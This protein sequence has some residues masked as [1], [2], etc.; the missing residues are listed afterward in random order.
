MKRSRELL[1]FLLGAVLA[2]VLTI[3]IGRGQNPDFA[4]AISPSSAEPALN[5]TLDNVQIDDLTLEQALAVLSDKAHVPI[6]IKNRKTLEL[7]GVDFTL[8]LSLNARHSTLASALRQ[9]LEPRNWQQHT[10]LEFWPEGDGIEVG[11]GADS[12]VLCVYDLARFGIGD[13][14]L[15]AS[16]TQLFSGRSY[17]PSDRYDPLVKVIVED[18][19]PDTWQESGGTLGIID[20]LG[21]RMV[22]GQTWENQQVISRLLDDLAPTAAGHYVQHAIP[23]TSLGNLWVWSA[24]LQRFVSEVETPAEQTLRRELHDVNIA[25]Q[26]FEEGLS[27]VGIL[28]DIQILTNWESFKAKDFDIEKPVELF[29]RRA[30][31]ARALHLALAPFRKG[32]RALAFR[33]EGSFIVI[34]PESEAS[35]CRVYDLGE[36]AMRQ[37]HATTGPAGQVLNDSGKGPSNLDDWMKIIIQN[38]ASDSWFDNGGNVGT[39]SA[40]DSKL[41]IRQTWEN[42]EAIESLLQDLM[43][44]STTQPTTQPEGP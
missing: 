20:V 27:A 13:D 26:P 12:V 34:S 11:V 28:A 10:D 3:L 6:K 42:Q 24:P 17:E 1:A 4:R 2:A 36:R 35:I 8:N 44:K 5:Q 25:P 23:T 9:V 22:I 21:D 39:I 37:T 16:R 33:P 14:P 38:V 19:A 30:T 32:R 40:F 41:V 15:R 29:I 31:L 7:Q 43:R 18:V